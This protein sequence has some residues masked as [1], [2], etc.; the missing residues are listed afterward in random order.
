MIDR[1]G[2]K[3]IAANKIFNRFVPQELNVCALSIFL[4][5]VAVIVFPQM[6][7]CSDLLDFYFEGMLPQVPII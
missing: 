5:C 6:V 1:V 4:F 7:D 3:I 2:N